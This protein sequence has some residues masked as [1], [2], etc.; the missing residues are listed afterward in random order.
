MMMASTVNSSGAGSPTHVAHSTALS[1]GSAFLL[2]LPPSFLAVPSLY[3]SVACHGRGRSLVR[4]RRESIE[5]GR[6]LPGPINSNFHQLPRGRATRSKTGQHLGDGPRIHPRLPK[7]SQEVV[8]LSIRS[9]AKIF[10]FVRVV[11]T[12][13]GGD[14]REG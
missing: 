14:F 3:F 2:R 10:D 13:K 6:A 4:K 12:Q 1:G 9:L 7:A 11:L 5:V 8:K